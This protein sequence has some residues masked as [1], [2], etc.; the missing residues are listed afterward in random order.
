MSRKR[1]GN[2]DKARLILTLITVTITV[3]PIVGVV[4][5]HQDN[6]LGMFIP[7]E[8]EEIQDKLSGGS[9]EPMLEPVGKPQ[10]DLTLRTITQL[11]EF[12]N[13]FPFEITINSITGD[14]KCASHYFH[15]GTVTLNKPVSIGVNE[16]KILT[17]IMTWTAA[18]E[19]HLEAA[20]ADEETVTVDLAGLTV[21]VKG[22]QIQ[23]EQTV[24][25]PNPMRQK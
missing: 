24:E 20:H 22:V 21:A 10:Y 18:A 5:V 16:T 9:E 17:A 23:M 14:V 12:K 6:L 25:I 3:A 7:P 8:I 13:P 15:L 11:I 2:M 1:S 19:S 4:L